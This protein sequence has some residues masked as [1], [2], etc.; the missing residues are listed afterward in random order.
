MEKLR[1]LFHIIKHITGFLQCGEKER[2]YCRWKA[3]NIAVSCKRYE[4]IV[5]FTNI[6]INRC[7][8]KKVYVLFKHRRVRSDKGVLRKVSV[9]QIHHIKRAAVKKPLMSSKQVFEAAGVS[10]EEPLDAGSC[11]GLLVCIKLYFPSPMPTRRNGCSGLRHTWRHIF[12][13]VLFTDECRAT[14]E[15]PGGVSSGWLVDGHQVPTRLQSQ[16]G[17]GGVMFWAGIMG[18]ERIGPFSVSEWPLQNICSS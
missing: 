15:G 9:R 3:C 7:N 13:T 11:R 6:K 2:S 14:L 10:G 12:K 18:S 17:A 16:Q 5:Y 4:H 1:T 8:V